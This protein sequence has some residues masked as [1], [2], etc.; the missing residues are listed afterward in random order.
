MLLCGGKTRFVKVKICGNR[1]NFYLNS[2]LLFKTISAMIAT[3]II[4]SIAIRQVEIFN[5]SKILS[6]LTALEMN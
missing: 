3:E 1:K 6:D 2:V 5:K 4:D